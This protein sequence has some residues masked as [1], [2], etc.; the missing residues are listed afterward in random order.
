[1]IELRD[2]SKRYGQVHAV[3]G[4]SLSVP[5]GAVVGV[6]GP[7]GAGK[8]TTVRM[9]AGTVPP[10]RG[11]VLVDGAD[12]V[13]ESHRVRRCLGYL[14]EANPLHPEMRVLEYLGYRA[15]LHG[16]SRM[17]ART[18]VDD[19]IERCWL[20]EMRRRRVGALSK[21]YRQRVGLAAAL[22]HNPKVLL[23]DEPTSGLDPAQVRETR[24]LIRGLAGERTTLIVSHALGEV[25]QTCDRLVI[26]ANGRVRAHGPADELIGEHSPENLWTV[27]AKPA[28][29]ADTASLLA[30]IRGVPGVR[31][32]DP[33][34]R[35]AS[36]N[37]SGSEHPWSDVRVRFQPDVSDAG[38]RLGA[39]LFAAG[40]H[41]RTLHR[42][43]VTLEQVYI[44]LVSTSEAEDDASRDA[45]R[46]SATGA[47]A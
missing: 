28:A 26:F 40:A 25:E 36:P 33:A 35:D 37:G 10:S 22:L 4:V 3:R 14:P 23:L 24:E 13:T 15:R 41:I 6:L 46:P 17:A 38:E 5:S 39:V 42:S 7:N 19:A 29:D 18:A 21:G 8:T 47:A 12:A 31:S 44:K 43:R 20:V 45:A 32:A 34:S 2:V 30:A 27:S 9:I 11:A 1:M 16:L